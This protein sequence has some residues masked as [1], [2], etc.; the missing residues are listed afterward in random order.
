MD[1]SRFQRVMEVFEQAVALPDA[2]RA[3]YVEQ[4]L[5]DEPATRDEV[6]GLLNHHEEESSGMST[7]IGLKEAGVALIEQSKEAL[8][9][10]LRGEYRI[11]RT[12]G[13]GGMGVVFEAEQAFPRRRVALKA[14]RPGFAT[15]SMLRRFR[16]EA[17]FLAR[18][19]HPGIAQVFE[20]G[21]ADAEHP[22]QAYCV[23]EL[24]DGEPLGAYALRHRLVGQ[25]RWKLLAQVC[26]AMQHAH[27]RGVIHRDL[28]PAN[29][30]ITRSGEPKIVDFG[31][32]RAA[33]ASGHDT[34]AT[35]AGQVIGTPAYMSPE[36]LSSGEVS[37]RSDIYAIGVIAYELLT[38]RLPIDTT[39][40]PLATLANR[41]ATA[42]PEPASRLNR[43]L[44]G[45]GETIIAKAMAK[46][47]GR[48]YASAGELADDIRRMLNGEAILA[49]RDSGMYIL[50]RQI[51]RHR[52]A[53][54]VVGVGLVALVWFA[55]YATFKARKETRLATEA[56]NAQ[57][58][59]ERA[60]GAADEA[61]VKLGAELRQSRIERARLEGSL[62]NITLAEDVLWSERKG[63]EGRG[64]AYW[65]LWELYF[66]YPYQW[67]VQGPVPLSVAASVDGR[68]MY[69]AN[70]AGEIT[71]YALSDGKE[72]RKVATVQ[73]LVC[74]VMLDDRRIVVGKAD[75]TL[76][77]VDV[78]DGSKR[79]PFGQGAVHTGGV[80]SLAKSP[81]GRWV[82]SGGSDKKVQLWDAQ[83]RKSVRAWDAHAD[84]VTV[85]AFS[86]DGT[87]LASASRQIE[88]QEVARVWSVE[89]GNMIAAA[90]TTQFGMTLSLCFSGNGKQLL[91]GNSDRSLAILDVAGG[92]ITMHHGARNAG[93][94]AMALAPDR[95]AIAVSGADDVVSGDGFLVSRGLGRQRYPTHGLNWRDEHT[96]VMVTTD[97][98][99]RAIDVRPEPGVQRLSGFKNW[100]FV[101]LYSK[102]GETL[103]VADGN[104]NLSMFARESGSLLG[105]LQVA[106]VQMR[107]R[108][109]G[110]VNGGATLLAGC[111]DGAVRTIDV[112]SRSVTNVQHTHGPEIYAMLVDEARGRALTGHQDAT[113][114]VLDLRTGVV[115]PVNEKMQRR[116]EG[117]DFNPDQSVIA[118]TGMN[119]AV[120]LWDA[121]TLNK[122]AEIATSVMPWGVKFSPDGTQVGISSYEGVVE[123]ADVASRKVLLSV[124]G[125]ARLIPAI[126]YSPDGKLIATGDEHGLVKL[127]DSATL[128]SL[129]TLEPSASEVVTVTFDPSGRYLAATTAMRSTVVYDLQALD[130]C[131]AVNAKFHGAKA[132]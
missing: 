110:E 41:V 121:E 12:I 27:S 42:E 116:V 44:R 66:K 59:A 87:R 69:V 128:R 113:M 86:S 14:L 47:P 123:V 5:S 36:Q 31:I 55:V 63:E 81:D 130:G 46:E 70:R 109:I 95:D 53:A 49:R 105:A 77:V 1:S 73:G 28:K 51:R 112:K 68:R 45:D 117:M 120:V 25:D 100:C 58:D 107:V 125:H 10:P 18:L 78:E 83:S 52:A 101:C 62:G 29:I 30:L 8:L 34:H 65:G 102:D 104:G 88:P 115:T 24:V 126:A 74:M 37:T 16:N 85:L 93:I 111:R 114:R 122:Q 9:P 3:A 124:K 71:G 11:L 38:G 96:V 6:L 4:E 64:P 79:E 89:S 19:Q 20:A 43:S 40:V 23:I 56:Q 75:G 127:W 32:A 132:E 97:G 17:E 82:A 80:R 35:R 129:A 57:H 91:V 22:D 118:T 13:E 60:K 72:I 67:T 61:N 90:R 26:D 131:I 99:V 92:E 76:D 50:S 98:V 39:E 48:R 21:V 15:P 7:G 103:Y 33:E 84:W 54:A 2:A 94:A 119:R 108:A 106:P